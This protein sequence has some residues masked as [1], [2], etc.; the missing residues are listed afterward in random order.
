MYYAYEGGIVP[1]EIDYMNLG[2]TLFRGLRLDYTYLHP[3]IIVERCTAENKK[4]ILNNKVNF[5][6]YRVV[7]LPGGDTFSAEAI[8]KLLD[9]YRRGGTIIATSRLPEK[10]SEFNRDKEIQEA[11]KEIFGISKGDPLTTE[12]TIVPDDF[13]SYYKNTNAN[14][15]RGYF[16]PQPYYN[17]VSSVLKEVVAVKDVDIQLAPM[18]PVKMGTNYDGA[19]TYIHKV[20]EGKDIYFFSN[21][22][23][24]G[25]STTVKIRGDKNLEIWDPHTGETEKAEITR[26]TENGEAVTAIKLVLNP[27]STLFFIGR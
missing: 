9:F 17:I 10:S 8:K 1:P 5:E 23:N 2:E 13:T 16:L 7:F 11:V 25:V 6:E 26:S 22:A 3:D 27:V 19:L 20:K 4:L 14:G 15:G 21:S 18:W 24:N 12:I